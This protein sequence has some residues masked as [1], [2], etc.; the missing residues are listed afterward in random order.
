MRH[1]ITPL[2]RSGSP[3]VP[4]AEDA[5]AALVPVSSRVGGL[6]A[7]ARSIPRCGEFGFEG[8]DEVWDMPAVTASDLVD[9]RRQLSLVERAMTPV[10]SPRLLARVLALLAQYRDAGLPATVEQAVAEDFLED[11]GEFPAWAIDEA[12]RQWR[13]HPTKYRYKPLCGDIRTLC[14]EIVGQLPIMAGRLKKMISYVQGAAS[15]STRSRADDIRSR[16]IALV[17]ARRMP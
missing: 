1:D 17:D 13:R 14:I 3:S 16:V 7:P 2:P 12:C 8:I 6:L 15:E 5:T 4:K 10:E 11:L 9:L